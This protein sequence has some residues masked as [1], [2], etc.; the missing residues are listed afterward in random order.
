MGEGRRGEERE[1]RERGRG[2]GRRGGEGEG[3]QINIG[4]H[5]TAVGKHETPLLTW[6]TTCNMTYVFWV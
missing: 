4:F 5:G 6:V 3:E 1:G 2:E